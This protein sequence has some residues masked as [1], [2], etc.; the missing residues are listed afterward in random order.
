MEFEKSEQFEVH[1]KSGTGGSKDAA[2]DAQKSGSGIK[3]K[4]TEFFRR[5]PLITESRILYKRSLMLTDN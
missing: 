2:A 5:A 4:I 3:G 1:S